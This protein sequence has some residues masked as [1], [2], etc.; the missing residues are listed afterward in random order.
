[1]FAPP[2]YY[3]NLPAK[4]VCTICN[5]TGVAPG[6]PHLP[7]VSCHCAHV[8][9]SRRRAIWHPV[10]EPVFEELV[11]D[12]KNLEADRLLLLA[13]PGHPVPVQGAAFEGEFFAAQLS[14]GHSL[15]F[16]VKLQPTHWMPM[17]TLPK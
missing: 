16:G 5:G 15:T 8:A 13:L 2:R 7:D 6:G 3:K 17:P 4:P 10:A 14:F 12:Y 11:A 1:M 9:A